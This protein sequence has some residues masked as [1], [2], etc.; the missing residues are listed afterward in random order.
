MPEELTRKEIDDLIQK[1]NRIADAFEKYSNSPVQNIEALGINELIDEIDK[2][3]SI[4]SPGIQFS[5][6]RAIVV[7]L[8]QEEY[9][10][11]NDVQD[12]INRASPTRTP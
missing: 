5:F 2:I 1:L 11:F 8:L 3:M 12:L 9:I 10:T 4:S 7:H 6:S